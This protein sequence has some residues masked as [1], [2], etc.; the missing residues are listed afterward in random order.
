[1][2]D[3]PSPAEH[4]TPIATQTHI[5]TAAQPAR[6]RQASNLTAAAVIVLLTA[7]CQTTNADTASRRDSTGEV[8]EQAKVDVLRSVVRS[9]GRTLPPR[10]GSPEVDRTTRAVTRDMARAADRLIRLRPWETDPQ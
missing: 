6:L 7:A 5:R 3:R 10:T 8:M 4:R 9:A 2:P 1:M